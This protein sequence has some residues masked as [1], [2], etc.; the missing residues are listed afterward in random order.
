MNV[1][2][3]F[4]IWIELCIVVQNLILRTR[5]E[6]CNLLR[7]VFY[8]QIMGVPV[9]PWWWW[10]LCRV[11]LHRAHQTGLAKSSSG[12]PIFFKTHNTSVNPVRN[13]PVMAP[14]RG[15]CRAVPPPRD[16]LFHRPLPS[17]TPQNFCHRLRDLLNLYIK[18]YK[19]FIFTQIF[20]YKFLNIMFGS[21]IGQG[22]YCV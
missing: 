14:S 8:G 3:R 2:N 19:F 9:R 16:L 13:A 7:I 18:I 1:E 11:P 22:Y 4:R 12:W 15:A 10:W 21:F 5:M 6:I 17:P 20:I